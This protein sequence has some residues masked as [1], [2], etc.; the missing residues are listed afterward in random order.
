MESRGNVNCPTG[1]DDSFASTLHWGPGYPMDP[2]D[3]AH[4]EYK[5]S[6]GPLSDDFHTYELE[7]DADHIKTSIDDTE[8]LNFKFDQ[9]MFTKGGFDKSVN[10]PW[11]YE[12]ENSAPF[13]R[14]FYLIFNV[15]VGGTAGYFPDGQCGKPWTNA[16]PHSVNAFWNAKGQWFPTWNYPQTHDSAMQIDWVKVYSQDQEDLEKEATKEEFLN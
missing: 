5:H 7:W 11:Q 3:K 9:D 10:N 6:A 13:N 12:K 16:D 2:W 4:A 14:E 15:A 8:V 1:G